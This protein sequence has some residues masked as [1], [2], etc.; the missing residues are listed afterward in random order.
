MTSPVKIPL[1]T[2]SLH[3]GRVFSSTVSAGSCSVSSGVGMETFWLRLTESAASSGGWSY[4]HI[5]ERCTQCGLQLKIPSQ[6]KCLGIKTKL[7]L[8]V[9]ADHNT[10]ASLIQA[11]YHNAPC[12]YPKQAAVCEKL[13]KLWAK[14]PKSS[15]LIQIKTN[16]VNLHSDRIPRPSEKI[17]SQST[18][19]RSHLVTLFLL[20]SRLNWHLSFSW[21]S[22][23]VPSAADKSI[24]TN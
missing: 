16:K 8:F 1:A 20:P 24:I 13:C 6:S 22:E 10:I 5:G 7:W 23:V 19:S 18:F 9:H 14:N 15:V 2:F 11:F 21:G 12:V 4:K 3:S 17:S